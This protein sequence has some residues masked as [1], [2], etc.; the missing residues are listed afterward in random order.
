MNTV[1]C[2]YNR[3]AMIEFHLII[4][5]KC[6]SSNISVSLSG[7]SSFDALIEQVLAQ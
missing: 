1:L 4:D 2:E 3:S 7:M 6:H 5:L